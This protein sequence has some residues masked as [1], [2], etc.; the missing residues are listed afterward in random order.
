MYDLYDLY[1]L[2]VGLAVGLAVGMA[3]V[4]LSVGVIVGLAVGLL[5][6]SGVPSQ[7]P[8][9]PDSTPFKQPMAVQVPSCAVEPHEPE[10]Y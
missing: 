1:D 5:H 2:C 7:A 9:S 3:V 4:G 8:F 6:T 10:P